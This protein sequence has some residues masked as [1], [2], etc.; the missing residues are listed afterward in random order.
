MTPSKDYYEILGIR[1]IA[2]QAEIELAYKGR[3]AQY[4]PDRYTSADVETMR[5][6]TEKMQ[7]VNE[8]YS[9]LSDVEKRRSYDTQY[10]S[11]HYKEAHT[12]RAQSQARK[13]AP[14]N[15]EYSASR[16]D[17]GAI[18]MPLRHYMTMAGL[19]DLSESRISLAPNIP[20]EKLAAALG[21]Y[22]HGLRGSDI[23][24]LIDDTLF[25]SAKNG[26][27][28]TDEALY[29]KEM[30]SSGNRVLFDR[31]DRIKTNES[32]IVINDRV[33]YPIRLV[34][35]MPLAYLISLVNEYIQCSR[36]V[37][38]APPQSEPMIDGERLKGICRQYLVSTWFT[39]AEQPG[40]QS[41][42]DMDPIPPRMQPNYFVAPHIDP[43]VVE[44]IRFCF[45]LPVEEEVFAFF[46]LTSHSGKGR[47]GF[48]ISE[49]GIHSKSI[50]SPN[51]I[52]FPWRELKRKSIRCAYEE[53]TFCGVMFDDGQRIL[54]SWKNH[55]FKPLGVPLLHDLISELNRT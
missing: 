55:F 40:Q 35:P 8:A 48:V 43:S 13:E 29:I 46:N 51:H 53:S 9:I 4:H 19:Q 15:A 31:I 42:R 21:S 26:A 7:E 23:A 37:T 54:T 10:S 1:P 32:M 36:A 14:Q 44:M 6:A 2:Q 49:S 28:F 33:G 11:R 30:G 25:G 45:G 20:P 3:R 38:L 27:L 24:V 39:N 41:V 34:A 50:S 16:G 5:W 22:G 18:R 47:Y 12:A 17:S 52:F